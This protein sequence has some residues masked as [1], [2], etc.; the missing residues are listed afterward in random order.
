MNNEFAM[1]YAIICWCLYK[2]L[3]SA[4]A[5]RILGPGPINEHLLLSFLSQFLT[6]V[7]FFITLCF[8]FSPAVG[9]NDAGND[10]ITKSASRK[11]TPDQLVSSVEEGGEGGGQQEVTPAVHRGDTV[12]SRSG[13]ALSSISASHKMFKSNHGGGGGHKH[14]SK[15]HRHHHYGASKS[16]TGGS[17]W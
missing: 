6:K 1:H 4:Q 2:R 15:H 5:Y 11:S 12:A 17:T 14:R 3:S 8:N 7:D 10:I 13:T 16:V 9:S